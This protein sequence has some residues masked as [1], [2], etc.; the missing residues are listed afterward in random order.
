MNIEFDSTID[1]NAVKAAEI[2]YEHTRP[3]AAQHRGALDHR[4]AAL[5]PQ[6]CRRQTLRN[7]P[8]CDYCT[9]VNTSGEPV[10]TRRISTTQSID[11]V[12]RFIHLNYH[13]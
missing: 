10:Q 7:Y 3:L 9:P 13:D 2:I 12:T 5:P 6:H 1:G 11:I 4:R 8:Q